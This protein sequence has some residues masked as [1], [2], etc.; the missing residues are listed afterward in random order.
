MTTLATDRIDIR[1]SKANKELIK[2]AAE[3]RGFKTVSE[4]IV[5]LAKEEANR[6]I[7][8]ESKIVKSIEDKILFT[9]S[10]VNPPKPNKALK[11]ALKHYDQLSNSI[12]P[13]DLKGSRKKA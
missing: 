7:E 9:E 5:T 8:Q 4:F 6:V 13:N 1:L 10:L 3:I 2:Y 12:Y 11:L